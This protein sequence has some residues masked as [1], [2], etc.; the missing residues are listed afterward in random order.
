MYQDEENAAERDLTEPA[1]RE[2]N[3][4]ID[5]ATRN[6]KYI[7]T[8]M[9]DKQAHQLR[10]NGTLRQYKLYCELCYPCIVGKH[11]WKINHSRV[12]IK[13]LTTVGDESLVALIMEN[14]IEEWLFLANGGEVDS[15]KRLTLYTHGGKDGNSTRKGWSLKGR[16]RY[17]TI[18]GE[19]K[20]IRNRA[21]TTRLDE[22]LKQL[23]T[24][25]SSEEGA[26]SDNT[27][28]EFEEERAREQAFEPAFDFDD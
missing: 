17:N 1:R 13:T 2:V 12:G 5:E 25:D 27:E 6:L 7:V 20:A 18:Y 3:D 28:N 11:R 8:A 16:Q 19:L 22:E 21:G 24:N 4:N 23:W 26:E 9:K 14:N 10:S 15:K